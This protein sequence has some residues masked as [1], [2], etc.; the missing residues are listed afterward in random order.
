MGLSN[1]DPSLIHGSLGPQESAAKQHL[2]RFSRFCRVLPCAQQTDT[3]T[4]LCM[5]CIATGCIYAM[6]VIWPN[7]NEKY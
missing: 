5:T 2:E 3:Q 4:T 1:L 6:H 7:N